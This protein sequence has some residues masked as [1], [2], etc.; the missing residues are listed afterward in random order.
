MLRSG[1]DTCP[2]LRAVQHP[3]LAADPRLP[4][5]RRGNEV[6]L[7]SGRFQKWLHVTRNVTA[8]DALAG[9]APRYWEPTT[10]SFRPRVWCSVSPPR[11]P[12][13]VKYCRPAKCTVD[14]GATEMRGRVSLLGG[15]G[16]ADKY[17][18]SRI[19]RR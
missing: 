7:V 2:A 9:C 10:A 16:E 1:A 4:R 14:S 19:S 11:M 6:R 18:L 17:L 8:S 13:T 15:P 3:G 5:A 12:L